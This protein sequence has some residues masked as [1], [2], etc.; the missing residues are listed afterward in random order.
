MKKKRNKKSLKYY[1]SMMMSC[2]DSV[3]LISKKQSEKLSFWQNLNLY[4]HLFSCK[5]CRKY[6]E[7]LRLIEK[8]IHE[9]F[10]SHFK[11]DKDQ[12][13]TLNQSFTNFIN[14]S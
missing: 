11:L 6:Y 13:I 1:L 2:E 3:Y 4:I 14:K 8:K 9:E 10:Y 7:D 12:K 5:V